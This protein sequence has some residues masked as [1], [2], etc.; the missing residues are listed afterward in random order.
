MTG[1]VVTQER[2]RFALWHKIISSKW[3]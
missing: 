3:P 2:R 1:S